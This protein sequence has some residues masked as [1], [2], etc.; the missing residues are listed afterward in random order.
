M[1]GVTEEFMLFMVGIFVILVVLATV[2]GRGIVYNML[3]TLAEVE[4]SNFQ[5]NV[6][7]ILTVAS[8]SPGEY[9][10]E[11]KVPL[12]HNISI[13]DEPFPSVFVDPIEQ[14]KLSN[15]SPIAFFTECEIVKKCSKTCAFIGDFC[16]T[17]HGNCCGL[18][19]CAFGYCK[20]TDCK[21][22]ILD[23]GEECDPGPPAIDTDCPGQCQENCTCPFLHTKSN[24]VH[25]IGQKVE[26]EDC[27]ANSDCWLGS[28]R[29]SALPYELGLACMAKVS[30]DNINQLLV[31]RKYFENG[32]CK[33]KISKG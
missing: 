32:V 15:T 7:T 9:Y 33:I 13:I 1:K 22:G 16:G 6:R 14:L 11:I 27:N 25:A 23:P 4:P 26:G 3:G 20:S 17:K 28:T 5:E 30:F 2:F 12:K 18:L 31:I 10:A 21:N 19:D 24:V 29:G 8:Y